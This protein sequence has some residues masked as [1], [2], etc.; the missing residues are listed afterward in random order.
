MTQFDFLP[1]PL[2]LRVIEEAHVILGILSLG[3]TLPS[4]DIE[5]ALRKMEEPLTAEELARRLAPAYRGLGK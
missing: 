3:D 4:A 1:G 5:F 2:V